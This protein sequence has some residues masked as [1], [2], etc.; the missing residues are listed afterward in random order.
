MSTNCGFCH[1][2]ASGC[3][4]VSAHKSQP[5]IPATLHRQCMSLQVRG[6]VFLSMDN[7]SSSSELTKILT[8]STPDTTAGGALPDHLKGALQGQDFL[9]G[10]S[11]ERAGA[12][13]EAHEVSTATEKLSQLQVSSGGSGS[14]SGDANGGGGCTSTGSGGADA[15]SRSGLSTRGMLPP[16]IAAPASVKL[17]GADARSTSPPPP[18]A[19]PATVS[20]VATGGSVMLS[21]PSEPQHQPAEP[22]SLPRSSEAFA[23]TPSVMPTIHASSGPGAPSL[24]PGSGVSPLGM[25]MGSVGMC[26]ISG[27]VVGSMQPISTA[28]GGPQPMYGDG[29]GGATPHSSAPSSSLGMPAYDL[30][31]GSAGSQT[32]MASPALLGNVMQQPTPPGMG[33]PTHGTLGLMGVSPRGPPPSGPLGN[34]GSEDLGKGRG[35][36][37]KARNKG[38]RDGMSTMGSGGSL[39]IGHLVSELP[40]A[41]ANPWFVPTSLPLSRDRFIRRLPGRRRRG[42]G[43]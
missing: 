39:G 24:P 7:S 30:P 42:R 1:S 36:K 19:A 27:A 33:M 26:H 9:P 2:V 29:F 10:M 32:R 23:G 8:S 12:G 25:G 35:S 31:P 6:Q 21:Q 43:W 17:T 13:N 40:T 41:S 5:S 22:S 4:E 18:S 20:C 38:G 14:N 15:S 28:A 16:G 37:G 11:S 3:F 34:K